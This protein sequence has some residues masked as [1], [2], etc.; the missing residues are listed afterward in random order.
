MASLVA[1]CIGKAE[2]IEGYSPLT[3]I[4]KQPA[5]GPVEIGQLGIAEDA[6]LDRQH[7]GGRDQAIYVYF[8]DDYAWWEKEGVAPRP[9]LFGENLVISGP[10]SASAAIGDRFTV[11]KAVLEVTYHRTPCMTFAAKMG[12]KF[13]VKR[14]HRANRPG[15]YCRVLQSGAVEAGDDVIV[16]PYEGERI[17]VSQ[18]MEFDVTKD[19]PLDFM[20]RAVTTPIREKTR[21]KFQTRLADLF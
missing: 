16:T 10:T 2:H 7:H 19:I 11:G 4:N 12:D 1:I 15:A 14:F 8:Q 17:T 20:R 6:I 18:L 13:W 9:G 21:F 5:A 3:G